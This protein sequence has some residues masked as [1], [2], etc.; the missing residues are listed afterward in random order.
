MYNM[1][2]YMA[3]LQRKYIDKKKEKKNMFFYKLHMTLP[4]YFFLLIIKCTTEQTNKDEIIVT[5]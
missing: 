5:V 1:W 2:A 3:G 4:N